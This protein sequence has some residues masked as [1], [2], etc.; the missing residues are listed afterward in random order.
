VAAE[1]KDDR[2]I[3][4]EPEEASGIYNRGYHGTPLPGGGLDL[5]LIEAAY[6][7][8]AEKLDVRRRGRAVSLK[9]IF[10]LGNRTIPGFEIKY[11]VYRDLRQRGYVVKPNVSPLDFRVFP[12]G[13]GPKKTPTKYWV[14]ALSER[15]IF[16]VPA[17]V[18]LLE[19]T[20][21]VRKQ[22]LIA[23]V[24]EESDLTYYRAT[25][26]E[27]KGKHPPPTRLPRAKALFLGD[28]AMVLDEGD[29][30]ALYD[31]GYFG[32]MVGRRLQLS[33]METAYLMGRGFLEVRNVRT[34]RR[35]S[36]ED[37]LRRA[38]RVQKDFA[39]RLRVYED[40]R[41][42]GIV[43][44]TGFK[45]GSHFRGYEDNPETHHAR[46]LIHALPEEF[47]G[48]WPEVSRAV[49]LAHGVKKDIL[50]GRVGH[51]VSYIRLQRVRP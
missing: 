29:A 21:N 3:L 2:V 10:R 36:L 7:L 1:L 48:M 24:D 25:Q 12:R 39:L 5:D 32:K 15:S 22:L 27:P 50:F 16:D 20:A 43:V 17:L 30:K 41:E 14:A 42:K 35:M 9:E 18:A 31:G 34:S 23:V 33:L 44:K 46:Y 26:V 40:L 13:G 45:Y 4:E 37:L 19:S 28:R 47:R 51:E 49:R 11:L 38:N 6:L 8:E